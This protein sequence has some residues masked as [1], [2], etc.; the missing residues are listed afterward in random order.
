M[1]PS[2]N[3][4]TSFF[5]LSIPFSSGSGSF[6]SEIIPLTALNL[7]TFLTL[8][9]SEAFLSIDAMLIFLLLG[10]PIS[11]GEPHLGQI[12]LNDISL[13]SGF[14]HFLLDRSTDIVPFL[15][16]FETSL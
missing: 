2:L 8:T 7:S 9:L 4:N 15:A 1:V 16:A 13:Q 3:V 10:A 11:V 14:V 6:D 5:A 12:E